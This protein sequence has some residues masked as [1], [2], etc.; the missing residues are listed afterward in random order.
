MEALLQDVRYA[1]RQLRRSP[2]FALAAVLMLALGIGAGTTVFS[3]LN[4]VL[5]R[6][7]PFPDPD[8]LLL[9]WTRTEETPQSWLSY[10]EWMDL[11][12][13]SATFSGLAA[14]RDWSVS[15][16][17]GGE[18]PEQVPALAVSA[19]LLSVLGVEPLLGRGFLPE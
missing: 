4:A 17:G 16:T 9:V 10:P 1:L 11:R 7:L 15:V 5:L 8:R 2:G 18:E 14:L 12:E 13:Q 3:M 6:P 19:N